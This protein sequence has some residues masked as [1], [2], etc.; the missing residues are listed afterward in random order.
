MSRPPDPS[1]PTVAVL[2]PGSA[3]AASSSDASTGIAR[4]IEVEP[5]AFR[6]DRRLVESCDAGIYIPPQDDA[7]RALRQLL[8]QTIISPGNE[9]P[10]SALQDAEK[11]VGLA[12]WYQDTTVRSP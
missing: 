9:I 11:L 4:A 2:T 3:A 8:L 1:P 6:K 12:A 7:G 10:T 5:I